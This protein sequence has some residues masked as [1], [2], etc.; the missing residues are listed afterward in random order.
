[1]KRCPG[2]NENKPR[3]AF[4]KNRAAPDGLQFHCRTCRSRVDA[5]PA[6]R[7]ADRARYAADGGRKWRDGFY[8]RTYGITAAEYDTRLRAQRGRCA[9]CRDKCSSGRRLAVD[10]NH[11]TGAIRGLLCGR[12]NPMLGYA[13]DDV[14]ILYRAAKYLR[15]NS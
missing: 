9:V 1:M 12:C 6:K 3:T 13:R 8:R 10:H 11:E 4:Q 5:R 2:C 15:K 7:A 14:R